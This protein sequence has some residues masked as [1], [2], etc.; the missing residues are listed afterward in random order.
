MNNTDRHCASM[1]MALV[2]VGLTSALFLNAGRRYHALSEI[3]HSPNA[4][5][6]ISIRP[7]RRSIQA[8]REMV[9]K[10]NLGYCKFAIPAMAPLGRS[11]LNAR[12]TCVSLTNEVMSIY[13]LAPFSENPE[14]GVQAEIDAEESEYP[15]F[16]QV[17]FM[18][19]KQFGSLLA[20][21]CYKASTSRGWNEIY[22]CGNQS[23]LCLV[24]IGDTSTDRLH[25]SVSLSSTS[26]NRHVG[27][28]LELK[29]ECPVTIDKVLDVM[30]DSF[31]FAMETIPD[32][33]TLAKIIREAG[34]SGILP[35]DTGFSD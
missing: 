3:I 6:R 34:N 1:V 18:D 28:H 33:Q 17:M 19:Q 8:S 35:M 14:I 20:E 23:I 7:S 13:W 30:L 4:K 16:M 24:R 32:E 12:G 27:F 10:I 11:M 25:A 22:S 9:D 2:V 26:G 29:P 15:T 5:E 21:L 31:E